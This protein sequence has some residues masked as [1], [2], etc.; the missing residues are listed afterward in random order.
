MVDR[1]GPRV[2]VPSRR[3]SA[4]A[5]VAC[6]CESADVTPPPTSPDAP[7]RLSDN[8]LERRVK[9]WWREGPYDAYIQTTPGLESVLAQELLDLGLA[10]SEADLQHDRGGVSLK[11]DPAEVMRANLSLRTASRVLL[12]LGTFPAASPEMLYDRARKLDWEVQ[13]G[14]GANY[15]LHVT[16]RGSNLQAGDEVTNTVASAISRN[17]RE[18]G[19]YPKA[20]EDAPLEFHVRLLN[21]YATVSLNS[22][23][24]LLHRRGVRRHVHA[25]P[26]R[27]TL[28]AAMVQAGLRDA[29]APPEVIVDPFLGSGTLL[30]EAADR[31]LG[32]Q[33]GR[34]R[35]FAFEHAAWFRPGRWREAQREAERRAHGRPEGAEA[36]A[37][38][39]DARRAA[40]HL[41][42]FDNDPK[43][44][45][46][47]RL[48][49]SAE[50]YGRIELSEADSTRLDFDAFGVEHGLIV[51]N[52]PYGVRLG[53]ERTAAGTARRFL[54]QLLASRTRWRVALLATPAEAEIAKQLLEVER[55]LPTRNGGLDVVLVVGTA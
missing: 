31:V 20:A 24:E 2:L 8:A 55:L 41:V 48:N 26:V 6:S 40:P 29:E 50:P 37:T 3:S 28:A 1:E 35:S 14:F 9:K 21:D 19:L 18:L 12:R 47:A 22:S 45:D 17:M 4:V 15:A 7:E 38:T 43:A 34:N 42:G 23:G 44:L 5:P 10:A 46:A 33:P 25:A 13:L 49:L 52:L 27:E 30:L 32:L 53:E 54:A 39:G 16:A 51:T 11:L 36:T